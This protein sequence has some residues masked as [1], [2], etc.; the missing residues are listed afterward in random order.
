MSR[1]VT[2][3]LFESGITMIEKVFLQ[4]LKVSFLSAF[5]SEPSGVSILYRNFVGYTTRT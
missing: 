4:N 3:D 2:G 1:C 5:D